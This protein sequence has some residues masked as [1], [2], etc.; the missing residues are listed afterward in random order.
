MYKKI[1]VFLTV[2]SI[3]T[4][5]PFAYNKTIESDLLEQIIIHG[6][7]HSDWIKILN[8]KMAD[9]NYQSWYTP[10]D[11]NVLFQQYPALK[12]IPYISLAA[13]P[14]PM[15]KLEQ[16][17][18][19]YNASIYIKRDDLSGGIDDQGN[20]IYGGNKVRKLEFLL[21]QAQY[22]GAQSVITFGCV[23]SNHA[24]A[25]AVHAHRLGMDC[26]CMLK[27]QPPSLVV[28]HNLLTHLSN[29]TSLHF[30]TDN[31]SRSLATILLWLEQ[32]KH[33][34][35]V[36]YIIPTGGSNILG[37]LGFV[38][39]AFELNEQIKQG[40]SP[41]PTHIYVPCGS[42]A[43]TAGLLLGLKAVGLKTNIIAVAVEPV[44]HD[45]LRNR[46]RILFEQTNEFLCTLDHTF[47]VCDYN[48]VNLEIETNFTGPHYGVETNESK[49]ALKEMYEYEH[50][51]LENTYSAKAFACL[52]NRIKQDPNETILFWNTYCGLAL[53]PQIYQ[54]DYH[55]LPLC[56]H[57]YFE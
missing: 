5:L 47:P 48:D 36:A 9:F 15:H 23:G 30:N 50:I 28:Q 29:N 53:D 8:K 51:M 21:A 2:I 19:T 52:L 14:T 54:Q 7:I 4:A 31:S 34:G 41:T 11:S 35:T 43:T 42:C 49:N 24:V 55:N 1:I 3:L 33:N 6:A 27:H 10:G 45:E 56:F 18:S 38:V 46:I 22:L 20:Y 39:A 26:T 12:S 16:I 25:T 40:L 17:S 37:A 13:L 44:D 57:S 32:Y